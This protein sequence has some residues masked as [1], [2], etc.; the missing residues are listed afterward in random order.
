MQINDKR[1]RRMAGEYLTQVYKER[2]FYSLFIVAMILGAL[3]GALAEVALLYIVDDLPLGYA[4][5]LTFFIVSV[6]ALAI[7]YG[8]GVRPKHLGWSMKNIET[9]RDA[10]RRMG[11]KLEYALTPGDCALAHDIP[12][13]PMGGFG[14]LDH[15]VLTPKSLWVIETKSSVLPGKT[16]TKVVNR[17]QAVA[18]LIKRSLTPDLPVRC[19]IAVENFDD[20]Q[21]NERGDNVYC[22][23]FD[24]VVKEI[25]REVSGSREES[26][27]RH[28]RLVKEIWRLAQE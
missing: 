23:Q 2:L 24:A 3:L 22:D 27:E 12:L 15:L 1:R 20:R 18:A 9:G 11:A 19:C 26:G 7:L 5:I 25:R 17:S 28:R 14:N 10:E 6:I 4:R 16:F 13:K 8:N 21:R